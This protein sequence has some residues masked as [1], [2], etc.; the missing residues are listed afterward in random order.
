VN[1]KLDENLG[2][3]VADALRAAAHG[4]TTVG[5]ERLQGTP[6]RGVLDA[7][8][9]EARCLVTL[10]VEFGNPLLF[11]PATYSGIVVIRLPARATQTA[12]LHAVQTLLQGVVSRP[13]VGKLWI[14]HRDQIRE[15]HPDS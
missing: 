13:V 8:H 3:A 5:E 6:D 1:F 7:A 11:H 9:A 2:Q 15:Y 12:L 10:D 4:V 14:V